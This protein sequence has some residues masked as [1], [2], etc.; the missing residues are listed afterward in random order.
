[1]PNVAG[2]NVVN[3]RLVDLV[4]RRF[5]CLVVTRKLAT[6][7]GRTMW[8]CRCDCGNE[9]AVRGEHMKRGKIVSCGC[10]MVRSGEK[11]GNWTGHGE[12]SGSHWGRIKSGAKERDLLLAIS[13]EYAWELFLT[14]GRR[15][16]LSGVPIHMDLPNRGGRTA[17][18]DRIDSRLGYVASNVQWVHKDINLMKLDW[19]QAEFILR[20]RDVAGHSY[21][22]SPT[23]DSCDCTNLIHLG[24]QRRCLMCG[25]TMMMGS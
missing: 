11:H 24:G 7:N 22:R 3:M 25:S 16:A 20:C 13:I 5:G 10:F 23:C 19:D 9:K 8:L 15:C 12:I 4:G 21:R 1:V 17:S 18:L 2:V 6:A 14:Q